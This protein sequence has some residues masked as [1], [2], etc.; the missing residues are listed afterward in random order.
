MWRAIFKNS[1]GGELDRVEGKTEDEL[2]EKLRDALHTVGPDW[3][4]SAGDT[5]E[6]VDAE[7][8]YKR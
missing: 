7:D 2:K 3:S 5:I 8:A 4:L 1:D 6:I